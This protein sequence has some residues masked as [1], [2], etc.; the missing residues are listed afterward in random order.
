MVEMMAMGDDGDEDDDDDDDD[1]EDHAYKA[2]FIF[3]RQ[4]KISKLLITLWLR[5]GQRTLM[6][7]AS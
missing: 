5:L 1:D 6:L 2:K 4:I 7:L 3:F